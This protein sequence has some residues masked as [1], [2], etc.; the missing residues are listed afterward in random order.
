MCQPTSRKHRKPALL[1][2]LPLIVCRRFDKRCNRHYSGQPALLNKH[3]IGTTTVREHLHG[4]IG[5]SEATGRHSHVRILPKKLIKLSNQR[6]RCLHRRQ[7][8]KQGRAEVEQGQSKHG[9]GPSL[10][11]NENNRLPCPF[12]RHATRIIRNSQVKFK[13]TTRPLNAPARNHGP[14]LTPLA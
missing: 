1:L 13:T 2:I 12:F 14:H 3:Y 11:V 7:T 4:Y 9:T 10:K 5:R 6:K 8:W